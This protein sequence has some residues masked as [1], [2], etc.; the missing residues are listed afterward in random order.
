MPSL[1]SILL[2]SL[3]SGTLVLL[4]TA[5][6]AH[7]NGSEEQRV[8][9]SQTLVRGVD[10]RPATGRME[11]ATR[12]EDFSARERDREERKDDL[13]ERRRLFDER[14]HALGEQREAFERTKETFRQERR[15]FREGRQET[16][17]RFREQFELF[18]E[19]RAEAR[20]A[21]QGVVREQA[22][23]QRAEALARFREK[24]ADMEERLQAWQDEQKKRIALRITEQLHHL[25]AR[26]TDHYLNF[27]DH[28]AAVADKVE[29]RSHRLTEAGSDAS[30]VSPALESARGAIGTAR[31]ATLAQQGKV[32]AVAVDSF[33]AVGEKVRAAYGQFRADHEAV[34]AQIRSATESLRDAFHSLRGT[35]TRAEELTSPAPSP[36]SVIQ[37]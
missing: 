6:S 3:L 1:S 22:A 2:G 9:E 30:A 21:E 25:N 5:A 23:A 31:D 12:R 32:Y 35:A 19:R 28:L 17:E 33:E 27:L 36:S 11:R 10:E 15:E 29:D 16:R 24:H 26:L 18:R 14:Q 13:T 37:P 34:R 20:D 7:R 8:R 4:M